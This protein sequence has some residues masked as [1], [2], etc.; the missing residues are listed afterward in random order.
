MTGERVSHT[1]ALDLIEAHIG[2]QVYIGFHVALAVE[3][4]SE[5]QFIHAVVGKLENELAPRPPRLN[6][7]HGY[8]CIGHIAY[9]FPPMVGPVFLRD[10]GVD[11]RVAKTALV[12]VAWKGSQEV[13]LPRET[14]GRE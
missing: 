12:R 1:E 10:E 7:D 11:F 13:G 3:P 9:D 8:Y 6:F 4:D 2:E 14:I 5:P